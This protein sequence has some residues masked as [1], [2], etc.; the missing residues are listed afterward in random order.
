M[1]EIIRLR[2]QAHPFFEDQN[3]KDYGIRDWFEVF[4]S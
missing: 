1:M 2:V 4:S 3:P